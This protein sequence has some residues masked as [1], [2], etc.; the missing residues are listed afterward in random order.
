MQSGKRG[1]GGISLSQIC[2]EEMKV[3]FSVAVDSVYRSAYKAKDR[4]VFQL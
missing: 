3:S 4:A 2:D 1:E